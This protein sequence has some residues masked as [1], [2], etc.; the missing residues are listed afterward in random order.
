MNSNDTIRK[1][2]YPFAS[3]NNNIT[4]LVLFMLAMWHVYGTLIIDVPFEYFRGLTTLYGN[5]R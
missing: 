1:A 5:A 4:L 2:L 3:I